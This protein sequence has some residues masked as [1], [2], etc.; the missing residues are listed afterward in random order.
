MFPEMTPAVARALEAGQRWAARFGATST[1]PEHLLHGL[2]E[3]DEGRASQLLHQVGLDRAALHRTQEERSQATE[4]AAA[5]PVGPETE[6]VLWRA[7]QLATNVAADRILGSEQV[8]QALCEQAPGIPA[9]LASWGVVR[10]RLDA[11]L[12]A[13]EEPIRMDEPLAL[14]EVTEKVD[15]A[16]IVDACANRAREALRVIEDYCRFVLDDRLLSAELK[17]LRHDLAEI[18]AGLPLRLLVEARETLRDVGTTVTTSREQQRYSMEAVV[19]ANCKRLQE[20]L[21]SLE[22]FGKLRSPDLGPTFERLRYRSYTLERALVLGAAAR[23][24]LADVDLCVLV[25]GGLCTASLEWT[26]AEAAAGGARMIQLREKT[27]NDRELLAQAQRVRRIT[28]Q[29]EVLFIMNDRPDVAR[30]AEA[31]GVHLGQE[32]MGVKEA[33]RIVGPGALIGVSTHTIEQVRAAVMDGASYIGVGPTFASRT[34]AFA[35]LAGLEFVRQALAETSLPAFAIGGINE[36]TI[37]EAAAAGVRR[38]AVSQAICA[39]EEP[40]QTAA[41]LLEALRASGG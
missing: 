2:L 15:T 37:E 26:I 5:A 36:Q 25:T 13:G 19:Q 10:E 3:E 12:S 39:A 9:L 14:D 29:A 16:R 21:R 6:R 8:L 32:D 28:R 33:R 40:R 31:D 24:Q 27:P 22:E 35:E 34:K 1:L 20:A 41:I 23:Q 11:V 7:R 38:V 4:D 17:K 18:L 30:L